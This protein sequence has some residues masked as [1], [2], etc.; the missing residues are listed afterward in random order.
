MQNTNAL[1]PTEIK[2]SNA[3]KH[4]I[5]PYNW[6]PPQVPP[7]IETISNRSSYSKTVAEMERD[8]LKLHKK[9]FQNKPRDRNDL[10]IDLTLPKIPHP[11]T[12]FE[13]A[14]PPPSYAELRRR[15]K[16][17]RAIYERT[18]KQKGITV[19]EG[20]TEALVRELPHDVTEV[21]GAYGLVHSF[22][23]LKVA[24]D[25]IVCNI[26]ERCAALNEGVIHHYEDP[27]NP[28]P[29]KRARKR[30]VDLLANLSNHVPEEK[31]GA[32][33]PKKA[34]GYGKNLGWTFVDPVIE[35]NRHHRLYLITGVTIVG[36]W[37]GYHISSNGIALPD[38]PR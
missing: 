29:Y 7:L 4:G 8:C 22:Q 18:Q 32:I 28:T 17:V 23:V 9:Q 6:L 19:L 26:Y 30:Y 11:L 10:K 15:K 21:D 35:F 16:E 1:T 5:A 33:D 2:F 27:S 36:E 3:I 37:I 38:K 25:W 13:H 12:S 34:F 14:D 20:S 24:W 31:E